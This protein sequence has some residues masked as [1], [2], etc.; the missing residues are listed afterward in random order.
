MRKMW[1]PIGALLLAALACGTNGNVS[2]IT[3]AQEPVFEGNFDSRPAELGALA[4][5]LEELGPFHA[6]FLL[7]FKGD[8]DYTYQVDTRYDGSQVEYSLEIDGVDPVKNPG[9]VRLVN[10]EGWNQMRG[11]GTDR[12]CVQF[13]DDFESRPLFITPLDL[14]DT[15]NFSDKWEDGGESQVAGLTAASLAAEQDE[16]AGWENV[17]VTYA[18]DED[19]GAILNFEFKAKGPDPL[20]GGGEGKVEGLF[21]VL[22]VGPQ[23]IAPIVG[24][25]IA[26]PMPDDAIVILNLPG[27]VVFETSL[28]PVKLD[29]FYKVELVANGWGREEPVTGDDRESMLGYFTDES[30]I[31]IHLEAINPDDFSEGY[32]VEV[33]YGNN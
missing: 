3:G 29:N 2:G 10:R 19:T 11:A 13:P 12:V 22:E 30:R 14:I 16:Y 7:T 18:K 8:D 21:E 1:L 23:E 33:F 28:G 27:L 17:E 26:I 15:K 20:F 32:T 9:D 24:C 6:R 5:S 4:M 31:D 25:E